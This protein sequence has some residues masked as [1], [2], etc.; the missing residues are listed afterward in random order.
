MDRYKRHLSFVS[1]IISVSLVAACERE[2]EQAIANT[3]S[4][5]VRAETSA[6]PKVD[7][8][9]VPPAEADLQPAPVRVLLGFETPVLASGAEPFW[10]AEIDGNWITFDRP[11][12]PLVEVPMPEKTHAVE[13][14]LSFSSEGLDVVLSASGCNASKSSLSVTL[15]FEEIEYSGCA[16]MVDV[17]DANGHSISWKPL[18]ATSL[19]EIDACLATTDGPRYIRALYPR[20]AGTIGMILMD[21]VGRLEECG[22]D[23]ETGEVAFLDPVTRDQAS[24]WLA[25]PA[26]F[27]RADSGLTCAGSEASGELIEGAGEYYPSGC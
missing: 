7:P 14:S 27:S 18:I 19:D 25:G 4:P 3:K 26:V 22:A 21:D 10:T 20:E 12:L 15:T 5:A 13:D 16:G 8:S 2:G 17:G 11:G 6:A 9:Y 23:T 24:I 1:L